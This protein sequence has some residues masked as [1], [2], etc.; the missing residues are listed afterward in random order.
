MNCVTEDRAY[1][2]LKKI[3]TKRILVIGDIILDEF[4]W[5]SVDRISPE[6]PVPVVEAK[7]RSYM[8]GGAANVARNLKDIG[9]DVSVVGIIGQDKSGSEIL[10]TLKS[11][12]I[13]TD[14]IIQLNSRPTTHKIRIIGQH[15]QIVRIDWE[16]C[17]EIE[18]NNIDKIL[19]Y[20]ESNKKNL[21]AV[22]FEDYGKGAISQKL[23][24]RILPVIKGNNIVTAFDP[25]KGHFIDITGLTA[26]TPNYSEAL[27]VLG[28]R[29]SYDETV[30]PEVALEILKKWGVSNL[31]LTL[32]EHGMA[33]LELGKELYKISTVAK[34]VYDVS[35]AGDTVIA[36]FTSALCA[37]ATPVEAAVLSN[38]AAGAVVA[39]VGTASV[40]PDEIINALKHFD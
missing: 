6:A 39:K 15:Q 7:R 19:S 20:V 33:F 36:C 37:G 27:D 16:Q 31:L 17:K 13:K 32:G 29:K 21:D 24:S 28:Y 30:L 34:E 5:G 10:E 2:I 25:K 23:I 9:V 4:I 40:Q 11:N 26:V 22:I 38:F 8:P 12:N 14:G 1:K 18:D 35:G 3:S